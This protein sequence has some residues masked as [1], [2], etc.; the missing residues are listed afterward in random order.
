MAAGMGTRLKDLGTQAPKGFL[1]LGDQAIIEESLQRLINEGI[2]NI[3]IVTGHLHEFYEELKASYPELITTVH[4][5]KFADSGSMYSLYL[6]KEMID[7]D[8]LL[9]ESDLIYEQ[10]ALTE[11]LAFVKDNVVMLSGMT[12]SGDE[13]YVQSNGD[14]LAKMSKNKAELN[15]EIAGELVGISKISFTLYKH[16]IEYAEQQFENTLHV[17]YETDCLVG[18][19]QDYPVYYHVVEDLLWS[20][21]DDADHLERAQKTIYPAINKQKS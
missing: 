3:I 16:M 17:D 18:V 9:L 13:V 14:R 20:E 7:E 11:A 4:N 1:T 5:E 15:G 8:F 2:H 19:A 12:N 21:I 6:A 10:R